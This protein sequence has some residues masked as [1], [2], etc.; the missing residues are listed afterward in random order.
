[1]VTASAISRVLRASGINVVPTKRGEE[2][3]ISVRQA[4]AG[5]V[6]L[7]IAHPSGR[8]RER[9]LQSIFDCLTAFQ[10]SVSHFP[11]SGITLVDI[12]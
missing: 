1:M 10:V 8:S 7:T 9:T 6:I 2:R 4:V 12:R 3:R 11:D 5:S